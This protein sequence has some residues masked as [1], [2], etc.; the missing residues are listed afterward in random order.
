VPVTGSNG[1]VL[2]AFSVASPANRMKG[3]RFEDELPETVL[4]VANEFELEV[5]L[6]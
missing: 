1:R 4:A 6:T 2:G 5:S 3:P